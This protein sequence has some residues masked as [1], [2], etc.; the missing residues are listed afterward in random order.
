MENL[1]AMTIEELLA[2]VR[3]IGTG[4]RPN[5]FPGM[6]GGVKATVALRNYAWNSIAARSSRECGEIQTAL[7]YEDIADKCYLS[8]PEYARW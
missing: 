6:N 3:S 4:V 8:L 2:F 1:D 5:L 7:M